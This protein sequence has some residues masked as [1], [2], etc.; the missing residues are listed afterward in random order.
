MDLLRRLRI[1]QS[2]LSCGSARDAGWWVRPP[3]AAPIDGGRTPTMI[4]VPDRRFFTARRP[5][6]RPVRPSHCQRLAARRPG[7]G[8]IARYVPMP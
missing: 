2:P 8:G 1:G 3:M 4:S 7:R 5:L 6:R